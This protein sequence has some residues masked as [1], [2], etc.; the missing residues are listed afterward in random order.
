MDHKAGVPFQYRDFGSDWYVLFRKSVVLYHLTAFC[1]VVTAHRWHSDRLGKLGFPRFK[2]D[3]LIHDEGENFETL[4]SIT[5]EQSSKDCIDELFTLLD[6]NGPT[7]E[8][9]GKLCEMDF[10]GFQDATCWKQ[11]REQF[12]MDG[13]GYIDR[14]EFQSGFKKWVAIHTPIR[15]G[16]TQFEKMDGWLYLIQSAANREVHETATHLMSRVLAARDGVAGPAQAAAGAPPP[17]D[18]EKATFNTI[19]DLFTHCLIRNV[20]G[21][22]SELA[23]QIPRV[24]SLSAVVATTDGANPHMN[25]RMYNVSSDL[26]KMTCMVHLGTVLEKAGVPPGE[27]KR[28]LCTGGQVYMILLPNEVSC[29]YLLLKIRFRQEF[30]RLIMFRN[31]PRREICVQHGMN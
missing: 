25:P 12:D 2:A 23:A 16:T 20:S 3:Q 15:A 26:I 9:D 19:V 30:D 7:G 13:N 21:H 22:V 5:L 14:N 27:F 18:A 28:V 10:A 31:P 17:V 29:M 6:T 4:F 8:P 24:Q 11:L 1:L